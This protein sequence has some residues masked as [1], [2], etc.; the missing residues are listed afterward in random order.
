M[1]ESDGFRSLL[2]IV[3]IPFKVSV[4]INVII[5]GSSVDG[6]YINQNPLGYNYTSNHD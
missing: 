3:K 2:S 5:Y 6:F 4:L 1:G